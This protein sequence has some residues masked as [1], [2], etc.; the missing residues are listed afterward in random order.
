V[1]LSLR[2]SIVTTFLTPCFALRTPFAR[3]TSAP[4]SLR[5][6]CALILRLCYIAALILSIVAAL[7]LTYRCAHLYC[8]LVVL[9]TPIDRATHSVF[10]RFAHMYR[11]SSRCALLIAP[12]RYAQHIRVHYSLRSW[13]HSCVFAALPIARSLCAS[14]ETRARVELRSACYF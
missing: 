13:L 8:L 9:R 4:M 11:S 5:S 7:L 14:L 1:L 6:V 12:T 10:I 2:S 3:R